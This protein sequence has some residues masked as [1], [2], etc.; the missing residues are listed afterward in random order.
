MV[1]PKSLMAWSGALGAAISAARPV[2]GNGQHVLPRARRWRATTK[3]TAV[4]T[5]AR[6]GRRRGWEEAGAAV[7]MA[8]RARGDAFGL[9]SAGAMSAGEEENLLPLPFLTTGAGARGDRGS[10]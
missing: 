4:A 3:T 1:R 10:P 9:W 7:V 8:V 2:T 5:A 6:R